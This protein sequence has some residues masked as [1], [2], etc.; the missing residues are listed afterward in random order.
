MRPDSIKNILFDLD[1]TLTDPEAGIT[2][3][4]QYA[5]DGMGV[6]CPAI[7]ELHVYIGPPIRNALAEIMGTTDEALIEEALR[8][9]RVRF[10]ETGLFENEVFGGVPEM[11][12]ALRA[13]S[14]RLFVATSKP[15]V[16]TE[17]ILDHFGLTNYFE[18][19]Y[20][21]ELNGKLDHKV[22]L[23]RHVL[24]SASLQPEE[25]LMIGDRM[26]DICGAKE[27]RC[28]SLGVTYGYGSE[29]EL[30]SAGA[31]LVCDSPQEIAAHFLPSHSTKESA[32]AS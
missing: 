27:N 19:I 5:L 10:A 15:Q 18:G 21:S 2:R 16:F 11:L 28:F 9:Y 8:L 31:D 25:T 17:R 23:I 22:E 32:R 20:G 4:L 30:R 24:S 26:Y 14:R 3:C 7:A 13:S 1:G 12:E 29:E 6:P